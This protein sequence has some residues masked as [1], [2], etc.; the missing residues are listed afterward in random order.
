[1]KRREFI[2]MLGGVA[3]TWPLAAHAQQP[4]TPVIG[5]LGAVSP[6]GFSERLQAFHQ[7]LKDVGYAEGANIAIE[8]RWAENQ[9]DRLPAM[10]AD[11]VRRQVAVIVTSGGT[12]PT[13]AAKAAT[14][15]IPIVF[16]IP[17][18]PVKLGIIG[19]LARPGGNLT[20]GHRRDQYRMGRRASRLSDKVCSSLD[21]RRTA[22]SASTCAGVVAMSSASAPRDSRT[23]GR[24]FRIPITAR[25]WSTSPRRSASTNSAE[26]VC[27]AHTPREH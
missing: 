1:M 12:V 8:Y 4:A 16:A 21:G 11:L 9:L 26:P 2:K 22:T 7:G 19:S 27:R 20:D 15:T 14:T 17:E 13:I 23:S 18:D 6:A 24:C 10:A 25:R 5:F 3:V